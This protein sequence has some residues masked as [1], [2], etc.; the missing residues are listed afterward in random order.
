[1][2]FA[3]P[4]IVYGITNIEIPFDFPPEQDDGESYD[5]KEHVSD[6][7]SGA[8]QVSVDHIELL[9]KLKFTF[10]TPTIKAQL[11]TFF[12]THAA[13]G[14]SFKYYEDK[15]LVGFVTY[16]LK[17]FKFDPKKVTGRVIYPYEID[18]KFRRVF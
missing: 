7:I 8:R 9:R 11:E 16:E 3:I 1:M 5:V 6:A 18:F 14:N 12:N 4:K 2:G 17:D 10:L 15:T 13:F